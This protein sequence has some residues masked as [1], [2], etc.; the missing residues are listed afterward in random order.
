MKLERMF[1]SMKSWTSLKMSYVVSKTRLLGQII[2]K[3]NLS[4]H[5]RGNIFSLILVR[6]GQNVCLNEIWDELKNWSS[7]VKKK[8]SGSNL[9][10][11]LFTP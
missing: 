9:R 10:K 4:V 7:R 2:K 1:A 11:N 6:L 3:K 8:V 5:S